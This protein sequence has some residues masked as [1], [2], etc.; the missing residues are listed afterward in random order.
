MGAAIKESSLTTNLRCR[1]INRSAAFDYNG[2]SELN[3]LRRVCNRQAPMQL[4]RIW[5]YGIAVLLALSCAVTWVWYY[6]IYEPKHLMRPFNVAVTVDGHP[7]NAEAYIGQP[8]DNEAEAYV[9]VH[10]PN[11]GDY[12]LNFDQESYRVTSEH[13]YTRGKQQIWLLKPMQEGRFQSPSSMKL[14]EY[15]IE[16]NGH[17]V[18]I[19]F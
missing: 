13:D 8:T 5:K 15:I 12:L 3:L 6:R 10:A 19:R 9:L 1:V 2:G 11:L 14:N 7:I 17:L 18:D 4:G 16:S